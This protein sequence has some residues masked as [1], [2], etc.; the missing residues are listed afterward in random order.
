MFKLL[1]FKE[2]DRVTVPGLTLSKYTSSADDGAAVRTEP[3]S[4]VRHGVVI[5]DQV[6]VPANSQYFAEMIMDLQ[7]GHQ[8][9]R[10]HK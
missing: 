3:A 8:Q 6:P 4:A 2:P 5:V 9:V 7:L 10:I 1:Q